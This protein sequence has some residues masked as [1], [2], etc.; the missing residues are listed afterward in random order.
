MMIGA[1]LAGADEEHVKIMEEVGSK[2]GLAFQIQDDILDV[3]G[4]E[5][6]LGKEVG[7]D[8]RNCKVTYV[9]FEGMEKSK[10]DVIDLSDEALS[11]LLSLS[12]ENRFLTKLLEFLVHREK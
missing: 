3:E 8:A 11:K 1:I 12:Y 7:Q 6:V 9:L 10:K 5:K 2:I 4:D